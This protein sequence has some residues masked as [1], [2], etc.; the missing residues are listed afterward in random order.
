MEQ[1][2]IK[3]N[4]ERLNIPCKTI[5]NLKEYGIKK[6]GQLCEKTENDL[7]QMQISSEY[8]KKI[9]KELDTLGLHLKWT[10]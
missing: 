1:K 7:M 9:G 8:I 10:V 4:I 3:Q 5:E 6:I 2:Y